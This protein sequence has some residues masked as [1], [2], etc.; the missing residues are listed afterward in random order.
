LDGLE[1][2]DNLE[3]LTIP[4]TDV[5]TLMPIAALNKIVDLDIRGTLIDPNEVDM[6]AH[7]HPNAN[8]DFI[9][10]MNPLRKTKSSLENPILDYYRNLINNASP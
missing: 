9:T 6:F 7:L 4:N 2:F 10:Y 3:V 8:I 5:T 1:Y